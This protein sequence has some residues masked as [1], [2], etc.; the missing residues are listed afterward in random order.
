MSRTVIHGGL[1][2]TASDKLHAD[3][4]IGG[5]WRYPRL[6]HLRHLGRSAVGWD[7]R[8]RLSGVRWCEGAAGRLRCPGRA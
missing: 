3:V 7:E 1:V 8:R 2:I 4:L 5:R 6:R